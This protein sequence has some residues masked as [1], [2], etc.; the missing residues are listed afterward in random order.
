VG[1][2]VDTNTNDNSTCASL[3]AAIA[4]T[5]PNTRVRN[6]YFTEIATTEP[7]TRARNGYFTE[8]ATTEPNTR[9]IG[10]RVR[11]GIR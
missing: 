6:G 9:A 5:E 2:V 1:W 10:F 7:N 3:A 8:I 11:F 4:T